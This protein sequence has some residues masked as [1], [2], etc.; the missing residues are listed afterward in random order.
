MPNDRE[1]ESFRLALDVADERTRT[2]ADRRLPRRRFRTAYSFCV[3]AGGVRADYHHPEDEENERDYTFD[4]VWRAKTVRDED[5]YWVC[6][7][8]DETGRASRFGELK[9]LDAIRPSR[10]IEMKPHFAGDGTVSLRQEFGNEGSTAGFSFTGVH[11]DFNV[12]SFRSNVVLRWEW[13]PGSEIFLVWQQ[14]RSGFEPN[15][16]AVGGGDLLDSFRA[17]GDD[18]FAFKMTWWLPYR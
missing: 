6:I 2:D 8:K 1:V 10:R 14:N 18:F 17:G 3:T 13:N 7:P 9:G 4:P 16:A 11:R 5:D 15:G 12:L